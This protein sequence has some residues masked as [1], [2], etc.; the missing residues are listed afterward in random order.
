MDY[1]FTID[2]QKKMAYLTIWGDCTIRDLERTFVAVT[3]HY[4]FN[5]EFDELSDLRDCK[6]DFR[7]DEMSEFFRMF[8]TRAEGKGGKSAILV[9]KPRETAIAFSHQLKMSGAR[10]VKLFST[11]DAALKW[12]SEETDE[13][14]ID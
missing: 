3:E 8:K 12:L 7:P 14:H 5:F 11:R 6:F 4:K 2:D 1:E 9:S 10:S 13:P